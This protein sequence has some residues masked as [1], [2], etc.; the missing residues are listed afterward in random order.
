MHAFIGLCKEPMVD[1]PL[2]CH[3]NTVL[4]FQARRLPNARLRKNKRCSKA[5]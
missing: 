5:C 3:P 1:Y 2:N 4:L